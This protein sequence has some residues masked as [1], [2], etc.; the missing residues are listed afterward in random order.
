MK[1]TKTHCP[2]CG[3][4][5]DGGPVPDDI[6]V[7]YFYEGEKRFPYGEN[8]RWH[9]AIGIEYPEKY[10]GIWEWECPDCNH[11]WPSVVAK[12]RP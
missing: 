5:L 10:D 7:P 3:T 2:S 11:R 9:R 4:D 12:L 1:C 8:A 6:N